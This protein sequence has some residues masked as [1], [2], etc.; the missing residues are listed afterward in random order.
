MKIFIILKI[1]KGID[2]KGTDSAEF[3]RFSTKLDPLKNTEAR[4]YIKIYR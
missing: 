4:N 1:E 3:F 2:E